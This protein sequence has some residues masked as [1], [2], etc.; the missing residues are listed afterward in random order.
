MMFLKNLF[1]ELILTT[2]IAVS[3]TNCRKLQEEQ[4]SRWAKKIGDELWK[5]GEVTTKFKEI[6]AVLFLLRQH[7]GHL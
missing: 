3:V 5:L 6:E 7:M 1:S 2:L 4:V